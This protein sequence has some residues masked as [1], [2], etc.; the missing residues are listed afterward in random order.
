MATTYGGWLV[1]QRGDHRSQG[2]VI[3]DC[4]PGLA[5]NQSSLS[6]WEN[7]ESIPSIAQAVALHAALGVAA[8][9]DA[10]GMALLADED[11]RRRLADRAAKDTVPTEAL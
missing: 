10:V 6:R 4:E 7:G 8:L 1:E 11:R 3:A 5:I 9:A 2:Q